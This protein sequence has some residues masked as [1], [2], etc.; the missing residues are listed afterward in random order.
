MPT[1]H[2]L[3][4][5]P[6]NQHGCTRIGRGATPSIQL[7]IESVDSTTDQ[8]LRL[9]LQG[10]VLLSRAL[11]MENSRAQEEINDLR[12]QVRHDN[13]PNGEHPVVVPPYPG[14]TGQP[15]SLA[16]RIDSVPR[17]TPLCI[18]AD[19]RGRTVTIRE[20]SSLPPTVVVHPVNIHPCFLP[21]RSHFK[22]GGWEDQCS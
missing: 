17:Q 10:Q 4:R 9:H 13:Q 5:P 11:E 14:N 1:L 18:V 6:R 2:G 15:Q 16:E 21:L 22:K 19:D 20:N 3:L 7:L 12:E 8:A